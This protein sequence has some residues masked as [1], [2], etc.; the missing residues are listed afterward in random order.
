V[1]GVLSDIRLGR[2]MNGLALA[3]ALHA[4]WPGLPVL[5]MSGEVP[6]LGPAAGTEA[7]GERPAGEPQ[8]LQKPFALPQLL[9]WLRGLPVSSV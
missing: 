8:F 9:A 5:L 7:A 3:R 4:R 1:Q 6:E 2:G